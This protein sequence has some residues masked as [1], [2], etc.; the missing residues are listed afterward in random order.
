MQGD[1]LG[2]K[3][4]DAMTQAPEMEKA[5]E[6]AAHA[7]KRVSVCGNTLDGEHVLCCHPGL[8]HLAGAR[9]R[10][11]CD[12]LKAAQEAVDAALPHLVQSLSLSDVEA[13]ADAIDAARY[14]HPEH[15]RERPRPFSEADRGD[16]EYAVRLARAALSALPA[17]PAGAR[18]LTETERG[19]LKHIDQLL[20]PPAI[21][22][23]Q[24]TKP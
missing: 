17:T 18:E 11:D 5:V 4:T 21:V 12:C 8:D 10:E 23:E 20:T 13:V 7:I 15:P 22:A 6:A 19:R 2:T 14:A 1:V 9:T 16:R 3:E 24:E